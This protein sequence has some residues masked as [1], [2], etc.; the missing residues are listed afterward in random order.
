MRIKGGTDDTDNA[1][2]REGDCKTEGIN[3]GTSVDTRP[4]TFTTA[5]SDPND[6]RFSVVIGTC[7]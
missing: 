3:C 6:P 4:G 1:V 7:V 5:T 2:S